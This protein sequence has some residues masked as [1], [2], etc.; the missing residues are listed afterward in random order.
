MFWT[1]SIAIIVTIS[2][3]QAKSTEVNSILERAGSKGNSAIFL[4]NLVSKPS[5]SKAAR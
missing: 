1:E 2:S 5:S 4:P 3:E